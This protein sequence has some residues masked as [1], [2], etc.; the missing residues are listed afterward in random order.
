MPFG[1]IR[2]FEWRKRT[3]PPLNIIRL[4]FS[5]SFRNLSHELPFF[6]STINRYPQFQDFG[7]SSVEWINFV[8]FRIGFQEH[9]KLYVTSS[10][11]PILLV[12]R[13]VWHV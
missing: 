6:Q 12:W 4:E 8:E 2:L 11:L 3:I 13:F 9:T 10:G 7:S 5:E 1:L